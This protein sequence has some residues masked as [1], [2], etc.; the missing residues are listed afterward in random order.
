MFI[1]NDSFW[2]CVFLVNLSTPT[3][4]KS[5]T[6]TLM[7]DWDNVNLTCNVAKGARAIYQWFRNNN[8]VGPSERH[9]FSQ[10]NST[11]FISPVKKEDIGMYTCLTQNPI[12]YSWSKANELSVFC[13]CPT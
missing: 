6:G 10:N 1:L 7:E 8:P 11:L 13:E 9:T 12:S 3:V 4:V 5:S 2:T